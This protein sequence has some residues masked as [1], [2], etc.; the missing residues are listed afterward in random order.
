M[1]KVI[2]KNGLEIK[3]PNGCEQG[4]MIIVDDKKYVVVRQKGNHW[5]FEEVFESKRYDN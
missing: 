5:G 4:D 1:I 3:V 2:Y